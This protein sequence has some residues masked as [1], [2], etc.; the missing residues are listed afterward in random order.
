L[1]DS[2]ALLAA[3]KQTRGT[4]RCRYVV[5]GF[6][7]DSYTCKHDD[8][9]TLLH[10][11]AIDTRDWSLVSVEDVWDAISS[12]SWRDVTV[13]FGSC[14]FRTT[15]ASVMEEE[16]RRGLQEMLAHVEI[17]DGLWYGTLPDAHRKLLSLGFLYEEVRN[18]RSVTVKNALA[19][20]PLTA[21]E[22]DLLEESDF[23]VAEV[24]E[25]R[26]IAEEEA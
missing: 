26:E 11:H 20:A 3:L 16:G 18:L 1:E 2:F 23:D 15:C 7:G 10:D 19:L 14:A 9:Y 5:A 21:D 8:I 6:Y 13:H 17:P 24:I 4:L 12:R 25:A 22:L